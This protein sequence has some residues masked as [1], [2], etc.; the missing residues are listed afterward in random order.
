[1]SVVWAPHFFSD[2]L[3]S[4][5]WSADFNEAAQNNRHKKPLL[6]E[7]LLVL[8]IVDMCALTTARANSQSGGFPTGC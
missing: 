4:P 2:Y 5:G 1:M 6:S 8:P 3:G 7:W